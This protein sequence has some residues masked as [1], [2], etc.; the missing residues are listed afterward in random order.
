MLRG[1]GGSAGWTGP[2]TA[3]AVLPGG[4]HGVTA[5]GETV[6]GGASV[7]VQSASDQAVGGSPSSP[8]EPLEGA[9]GRVCD[10]HCDPFY[11]RSPVAESGSRYQPA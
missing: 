4:V 1:D 2:S 5:V 6:T 11:Q 7:A 8:A 10:V 9:S 3:N